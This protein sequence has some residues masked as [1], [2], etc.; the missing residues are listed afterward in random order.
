MF[1]S[2]V[3]FTTLAYILET[4]GHDA[5]LA[6]HRC[7]LGSVDGLRDDGPWL[8]VGQLEALMTAA[9]E[10][11]RDPSFGLV[12][13]KSKALMRYVTLTH[14]TLVAPTLRHVLADIT[15]F[16]ALVL[17]KSEV[18]LCESS[19]GARLDVTPVVALGTGGRFRT[20]LVATSAVQMIGFARGGAQDVL[21]V[22]FPYLCPPDQ[23]ARYETTFGRRVRFGRD[24]C[25]V[26]FNASLLDMPLQTHDPLA[27]AQAHARAE[28]ALSARDAGPRLVEGVR[29]CLLTAL[30]L[31]LSL[32][33]TAERL[34]L[35]ERGLRR[36]LAALGV[37]H[38]ELARRCLQQAAEDALG[39]Q[40]LATKQVASRL[41]F[42]SVASFHRA[43]RRWTGQTPVAWRTARSIQGDD[44]DSRVR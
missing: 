5:A 23:A 4:E 16:A 31:Q 8:P 44:I 10:V 33:E 24:R 6:L 30:P 12:A 39:N 37:S 18:T 17:D 35:T 2:P 34:N 41:G 43:F 20:E 3:N 28:A 9:V 25:S 29:R 19:E 36:R 21:E 40:R 7:G 15:R 13:G 26:T 1:A 22:E 11:S 27:Y 14:V 42:S 32:R 38:A